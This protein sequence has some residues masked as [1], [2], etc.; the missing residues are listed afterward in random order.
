M[1]DY[2]ELLSMEGRTAVVTGAGSGIGRATAL[3]LAASGAN[4][5]L[6]DLHDDDAAETGRRMRDPSR[7]HVVRID[8]AEWRAAEDLVRETRTR[9]ACVDVLV[10]CA[11]LYPSSA[12]GDVSEAHWDRLLDVNLKG[13]MRISQAFLPLLTRSDRAAI[14]N[15]ASVQAFRPSAGKAAYA[16]SKAGI[17]ALTEVLAGELAAAGVRVNAVAPGP[18]RTERI[19]AALRDAPAAG[20]SRPP[21]RTLD[22][23]P[24]GRFGEP[25][26]VARVIHFLASAA[27]SFVTGSTWVVDGGVLLGASRP[28]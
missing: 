3:R 24:L 7:A 19:A 1:I 22:Q 26:E 5:V 25:D 20:A 15:V 11:G 9:S 18:I 13:T 8:V 23:V 17:V 16:A 12:A 14:V 27:A 6:A 10:N 21:G 2:A 28:T 4:V